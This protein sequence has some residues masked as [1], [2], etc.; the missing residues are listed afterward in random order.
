MSYPSHPDEYTEAETHQILA[1]PNRRTENLGD[2]RSDR[3]NVAQNMFQQTQLVQSVHRS[4]HNR[5]R[6]RADAVRFCEIDKSS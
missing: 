4:H 6:D 3:G 2:H 5:L 1:L